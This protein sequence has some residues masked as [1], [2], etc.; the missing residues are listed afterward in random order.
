[1]ET[2]D[3]KLVELENQLES[4]A[5]R[6]INAEGRSSDNAK[7]IVAIKKLFDSHDTRLDKSDQMFANDKTKIEE[8]QTEVAELRRVNLEQH[9]RLEAHDRRMVQLEERMA[10]KTLAGLE[11]ISYERNVTTVLEVKRRLDG[12]GEGT[13]SFEAM[14]ESFN[15]LRFSGRVINWVLGVGGIGVFVFVGRSFLGIG[16]SVPPEVVSIRDNVKQNRERIEKLEDAVNSRD[17][18]EFTRRLERLEENAIGRESR[19]LKN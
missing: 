3:S 4:I 7:E 16:D 10:G 14:R 1:M 2:C 19:P 6:A 11:P 12:G 18:S 15:Q 13:P 17:R 9:N 8:L 5:E